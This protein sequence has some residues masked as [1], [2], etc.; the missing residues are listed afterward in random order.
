MSNDFSNDDG[1]DEGICLENNSGTEKIS[2][3]GLEKV[4]FIIQ[5]L[6]QRQDKEISELLYNS[7]AIMPNNV[8]CKRSLIAFAFM[9]IFSQN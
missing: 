4:L 2:K 5:F 6:V 7:L 1:V 3:P 8:L 9:H